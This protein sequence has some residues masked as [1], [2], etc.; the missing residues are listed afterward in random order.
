MRR[1]LS[2]EDAAR[3]QLETA[4]DLY[5]TGGDLVASW[6]LGAAAYNVLRDLSKARSLKPMPLK[7]QLP[8]LVPPAQR[9]LLIRKI[10]EVENFFKH[11]DRDPQSTLFFRPQGQIELLLFD[12]SLRFLELFAYET[13]NMVL[14]RMWFLSGALLDYEPNEAFESWLA[15]TKALPGESPEEYRTRMWQ[16]ARESAFDSSAEPQPLH[17]PATPPVSG[18]P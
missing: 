7:E 16:L 2:K 4:I 1:M 9:E 12:A 6:T 8:L 11:A 15:Q 18:D 13:A 5:F 17:R 14:I 3:R 10:Q